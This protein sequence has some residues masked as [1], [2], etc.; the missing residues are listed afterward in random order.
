MRSGHQA[1]MNDALAQLL[2]EVA[3]SEIFQEALSLQPSRLQQLRDLE[4]LGY[5]RYCPY[6][7]EFWV[8]LSAG[9]EF[10][11]GTRLAASNSASSSEAD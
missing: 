9:K 11:S 10:L 7:E 4:A 5:I 8:V 2:A 6:P 1:I 3:G